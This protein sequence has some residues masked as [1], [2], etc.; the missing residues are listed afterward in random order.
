MDWGK[1]STIHPLGDADATIQITVLLD[2]DVREGSFGLLT[3]R[4]KDQD[5]TA[6]QFEALAKACSM[7]ARRI[8]ERSLLPWIRAAADLDV[9]DDPRV[10]TDSVQIEAG[11]L[12][13]YI[14][15]KLRAHVKVGGSDKY[16]VAHVW[17]VDGVLEYAA[18]LDGRYLGGVHFSGD[19]LLMPKERAWCE[20]QIASLDR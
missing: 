17:D 3:V 2:E 10:K 20:A 12:V 9:Y 11:D 7:A 19:D 4:A 15:G 13:L 8:R 14:D 5:L 18:E 1:H 16:N 6:E